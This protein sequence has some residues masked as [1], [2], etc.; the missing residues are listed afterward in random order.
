MLGLLA[1]HRRYAHIT[2]LRADAVAAMALGMN[3]SISEDALCSALGRMDEATSTAWMRP[4]LMHL[5]RPALNKPWV[6]NM[7]ATNKPV[8]GRPEGA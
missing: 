6:L 3:K 7:D 8:Y 2:V 4:M 1:E 5:A